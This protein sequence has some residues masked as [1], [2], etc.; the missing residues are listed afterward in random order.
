MKPLVYTKHDW[1]PIWQKIKQANPPSVYLIRSR[2][3]EV[4]GFTVREYHSYDVE[5][6]RYHDM[7]HLDFYS[8]S[9]RTMFLLRYSK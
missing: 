9:A 4:L 1:Y 2:C 7:I 8:E 5:K 6:Q 3:R